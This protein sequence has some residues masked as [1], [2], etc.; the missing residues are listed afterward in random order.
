MCEEELFKIDRERMSI[1]TG[2]EKQ[3]RMSF[4]VNTCFHSQKFVTVR[5]TDFTTSV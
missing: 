4:F 1:K 2:I 3:G 5:V